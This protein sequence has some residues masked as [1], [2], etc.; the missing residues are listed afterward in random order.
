MQRAVTV[1]GQVRRRELVQMRLSCEILGH[2]LQGITR[3]QAADLRDGA[4]GWSVVEVVCH[5]RDFDAVF[6]GRAKMMLAQDY[7]QLPAYDHE[8]MAVEG[9][10]QQQ[11]VMAAYEQLR[12]SRAGFIE[13]FKALSDA[14]WERGGLHPE[15]G[16]FTMTDALMQVGLHDL[17]HLEQITRIL[18]QPAG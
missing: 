5:L 13:F 10:Y 17:D 12:N 1:L 2:I 18:T 8:A 4:A 16:G 15:K 14:E 3:E 6:L 7:P 9:G 11:D